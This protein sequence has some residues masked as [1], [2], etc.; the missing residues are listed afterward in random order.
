M[1]KRILSLLL[2]V[3][4]LIGLLPTVALAEEPET[5]DT[6]PS[7][8]VQYGS[9]DNNNEWKA[10]ETSNGTYTDPKTGIK[11]SKTA[12]PVEGNPN[13]YT[14]TLRV[15]METTTETTKAATVL[16]IDCSTS[17]A[18]NDCSQQEHTHGYN[19]YKNKYKDECTHDNNPSHWMWSDGGW[20]GWGRGW[21]HK[22]DNNRKPVGGCVEHNDR[23]Y[24]TVER[25]LT[26]TKIEHRHGIDCDS[27]IDAAKAAAREF[28]KTY[29]TMDVDTDGSLLETAT[30]LSIGRYVSVVPFGTT[31][32]CPQNCW[33]DVS[34]KT[35][36]TA[37]LNKINSLTAPDDNGTNLDAGL[38]VADY[39]LNMSAVSGATSKNVIALTD[40]EPTYYLS[41]SSSCGQNDCD[42]YAGEMP[43]LYIGGQK[44]YVHG[45]GG[46]CNLPT[47]NTTKST[48]AALNAETKKIS[49]Y[50]VC[51]GVADQYI[52]S[53]YDNRGNP[54]YYEVKV[55]QYLK[56][57]IAS[58]QENAFDASNSAGLIEAFRNIT[59]T[60]VTG[61]SSGTV[62]DSVPAAVST[63]AFNGTANWTLGGENS[64]FDCTVIQGENGKTS[65]IYTK[66][67]TVTIGPEKVDN[68]TEYQP[69]NGETY[70]SYGENGR[71]DFPIPAG[72]VTYPAIMYT[73]KYDANGGTGA[74]AGDTYK[75]NTGKTTSH[76]FDITTGTP[77]REGYTFIGWTEDQNGTGTVY[78]HGESQTTKITVSK[79]APDNCS[80][81]LYAQ[82]TK[83]PT[84]AAVTI[85]KEFAGDE[86]NYPASSIKIK[87]NDGE[88]KSLQEEG[89]NYTFGTFELGEGT[90]T[91]TEE[92]QNVTGYTCTTKIKGTDPASMTFTIGKGNLGSEQ[93]ITVVNTYSQERTY[94]LKYDKN[95]PNGGSVSNMPAQATYGPTA[96]NS[97][98]FTVDTK[99][100]ERTG[101]TFKYWS[102]GSTTTVDETHYGHGTGLLDKI[103][104][105]STDPDCT[106]TLYAQWQVNL[107][108]VTYKDGVNGTVFTD[109]EHKD[110]VY[111][112]PIP[113]YTDGTPTRQGYA[114]NGWK[115]YN[116]TTEIDKPDTMPAQNL[117]AVAQW[118]KYENAEFNLNTD[119]K[120]YKELDADEDDLDYL[121][122][123]PEA[124]Y[125]FKVNV[126]EAEQDPTT[127]YWAPKNSE[128][129][130]A[131]GTVKWTKDSTKLQFS[132]DKPLT[133][134]TTGVFHYIF[135]EQ[136]DHVVGMQYDTKARANVLEIT[137]SDEGKGE[138]KVDGAFMNGFGGQTHLTFENRYTKPTKE[139]L[140]TSHIYGL[141]NVNVDGKPVYDWLDEAAQN[142]QSVL[143]FPDK[144]T[145]TLIVDKS[146][147]RIA[148]AYRVRINGDTGTVV[149]VKDDGAI[150]VPL[151]EQYAA[152]MGATVDGDSIRVEFKRSSQVV[153]YFI[154]IVERG[155]NGEFPSPVNNTAV[156]NDK[157][158]PSDNT[159]INDKTPG[160]FDF[161]DII[162]KDLYV[163]G[164]QNF[165]S[166]LTFRAKLTFNERKP[167]ADMMSLPTEEETG[168]DVV[169]VW[170]FKDTILTATFTP[171]DVKFDEK[172]A[173]VKPFL[174]DGSHLFLTFP[175]E[176][177]Y[178]FTLEELNDGVDGVKY[179]G[180]VYTIYVT[181]GP[182]GE[183]GLKVESV[184]Y[185]TVNGDNVHS[186]ALYYEGHGIVGHI[187]FYNEVDTGDIP[188]YPIIPILPTVKDEG[189]LNKTDHFAY[190]IGYP[191]GT[192]HPNGEIT[193]AEVATIFFRLLK[194]DVRNAYFTSYNT[195]S[196]VKL[197]KWYNNPI[198]TMS[199]LG[200]ING[201]PDGTFRPDA[202]ITRAEFAAIAA[203]FDETA[204]RGTT[205]FV[206]VYGH[207]AADEIAKAYG[208][209][210]IKGYPDGTFRPDRN[211]TRAEAMTLINRVLD[212]APE[213][214]ADLLPDM[215]KW[216]DNMD[217]TKW[218]Y[219]AI[220]EATNS[221]DYT[222]KTFDYEMWKRMLLDPDWSRY[223][224]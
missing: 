64:D 156:V 126:Y 175:A 163:T 222:R 115:W 210:W 217:T 191:D 50:T 32:E 101:Y 216:S 168:D 23:Y 218:Y 94:T 132:F 140:T 24:K 86:V 67:Y 77:T 221:H 22:Y 131:T 13:E 139:T 90:Y 15:E 201:Y 174:S 48:A 170:T 196:D 66:T 72:K 134:N 10:D 155:A 194:D 54:Y 187:T 36:Y 224:R 136:N 111:N 138:Y 78:G 45:A 176:G 63:N 157:E 121:M 108:T 70:L 205:T 152:D 129:I 71:I 51:F 5:G 153:L 119:V 6:T 160:G 11:V 215:N 97:Y 148:L 98:E 30:D 75:D 169:D 91:I 164:D 107:Y 114:F 172:N 200:I 59:Q 185:E 27:K 16:V 73:L 56:S 118:K 181:V 207:W 14:V 179:D 9:Y 110:V 83:N 182:D 33:F 12:E 141:T 92:G 8:N 122:S 184:G 39:Q 135:L 137:V 133:F 112:T 62:T 195:Y 116:G 192:V 198:S 60:I 190:I 4:M 49:T 58:K 113:G 84:T 186:E 193:R 3:V 55:G 120:V 29:S 103:T 41:T 25:T 117:V 35:G 2:A 209:D 173:N 38:R 212:R 53:G 93:T 79:A 17:M 100:P 147:D 69:L 87:L 171:D 167:L 150:Y 80:K 85:N 46:A 81:T 204:T 57:H 188:Y 220:Q 162:L 180:T 20:F 95:V 159:Y 106:K 31:A 219:L 99:S 214:P 183:T 177:I 26:C 202:P 34:T 130:D 61:I 40:G 178:K 1:K 143:M 37:V 21:Y 146:I 151:T 28:L 89:T 65:Y 161:S 42:W 211:I 88:W 82:W 158:I 199:A 104:V 208:N 19:C 223:E 47:F 52:C 128:K 166:S 102:T 145:K 189:K 43:S 127:T 74:P 213:S 96:E 197:G 206:D 149:T 144:D 105:S 109:D 44:W 18:K 76:E 123:L 7:S 165:P 124:A 68:D 142:K 154:K 203:R 125:T